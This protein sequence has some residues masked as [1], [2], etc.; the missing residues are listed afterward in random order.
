MKDGP[1]L[2]VTSDDVMGMEAPGNLARLLRKLRSAPTRRQ[3]AK[4]KA[5][6]RCRS[7]KRKCDGMRPCRCCQQAGFKCDD[8]ED[9]S[10]DEVCWVGWSQDLQ[11]DR[12]VQ[13]SV[14][15]CHPVM[16]LAGLAP[17]ET[18]IMKVGFDNGIPMDSLVSMFSSIPFKLRTSI[19]RLLRV[20]EALPPPP[21]S[22]MPEDVDMF[23]ETS[24]I[25]RCKVIFN[26]N[27]RIFPSTC[28]NSCFQNLLGFHQEEI[29]ARVSSHQMPQGMSEFR[30]LCNH[31]QLILLSILGRDD[32][33]MC[34][35]WTR[36]TPNCKAQALFVRCTVRSYSN[37]FIA[38]LAVVT[39]DEYDR[40]QEFF[41]IN[42]R[43]NECKM[44]SHEILNCPDLADRE[45]ICNMVQTAEGKGILDQLGDKIEELFRINEMEM[46]VQAMMSSASSHPGAPLP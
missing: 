34:P 7:K 39:A 14:G 24:R 1:R 22:P 17:P 36:E 23:E 8:E 3:V 42:P 19:G 45:K 46:M 12:P 32:V 13:N 4:G 43:I 2:R 40:A 5:C 29:S 35:F 16:Q 37:G 25:S 31:L 44:T 20:L 15:Y 28:Y 30:M 9:D 10:S 33:I 27:S 21:L 11:I 26:G 41:R 38:T 18:R 6:F